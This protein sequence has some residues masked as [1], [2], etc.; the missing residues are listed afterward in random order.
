MENKRSLILGEVRR[1]LL[2]RTRVNRGKKEGSLL[3]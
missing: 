2:P 3:R 1:T